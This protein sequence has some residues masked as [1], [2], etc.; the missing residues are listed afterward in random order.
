MPNRF[1]RPLRWYEN[2]AL[3][4]LSQ[5]PRIDRIILEQ[6]AP[7]PPED[8]NEP[9]GEPLPYTMT[10]YLDYLYRRPSATKPENP[11]G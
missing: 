5:S 11:Q 3:F 9:D 7:L 10:K 8:A 4:L 2:L 1:P 6:R